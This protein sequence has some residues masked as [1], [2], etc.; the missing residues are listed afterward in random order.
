M[1]EVEAAARETKIKE[2]LTE[3]QRLDKE[4]ALRQKAE[5]LRG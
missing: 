2:A 3:L 5:A 1:V 4:K